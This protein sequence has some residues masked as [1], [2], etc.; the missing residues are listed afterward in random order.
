MIG[1][2]Q[3]RALQPGHDLVAGLP[4]VSV[5]VAAADDGSGVPLAGRQIGQQLRNAEKVV[6]LT[7]LHSLIGGQGGG[8]ILLNL[9]KWHVKKTLV[10][11]K[12]RQKLQKKHFSSF[13]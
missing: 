4:G 11:Y 9:K 2:E 8:S 1:R 3:A 7:S 12:I 10:S 5:E 6:D 13:L